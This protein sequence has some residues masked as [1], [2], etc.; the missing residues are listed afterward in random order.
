M[1]DF[2][3]L[4]NQLCFAIYETSSQFHKL[5]TKVLDSFGLT[6]PQ[7]LVLL[8]LWEEDG[9][10][11]KELGNK[12]NLGTGTLT[13]MIK[14]MEANDWV[15]RKR[16]TTDERKISILLSE[17]AAEAK[18][19]ITEKVATTIQSCQIDYDEYEQLLNQLKNLQSKLKRT[20]K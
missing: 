11:A 7:Y 20:L 6:Y 14:R 5:Y 12:L 1:D 4:E 2:L 18:E 16:S 9:L 10:T 15:E 19:A 17:K 13:P 3:T 8:A